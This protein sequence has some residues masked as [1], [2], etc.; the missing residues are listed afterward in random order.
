MASSVVRQYGLPTSSFRLLWHVIDGMQGTVSLGRT[1]YTGKGQLATGDA[2][3]TRII[4]LNDSGFAYS[5]NI[6]VRD[7]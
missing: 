2:G 7:F 5:V 6:N 4:R 3:K 1:V